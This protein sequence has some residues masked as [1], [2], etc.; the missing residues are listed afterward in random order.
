MTILADLPDRREQDLR[1][2]DLTQPQEDY[3]SY[4][5]L[6]EAYHAS[7]W[8]D[9]LPIVPP[10]PEKTVEF[11]KVVGL[12]PR[13]VVG[14]VPTRELTVSAEQLAINAVMAGC[15][16]EYMP[17]VLAAARAHLSPKGN[18]HSTTATLAGAVHLVLVNG[19]VRNELGILCREGCFG[20]GS[21]AN[22]TI[23]RALRLMIRNACHAVPGFVDRATFSHPGRYSACFGEDEEGGMRDEGAPWLPL[24]VERGFA[25]ETNVVTVY[26]LTDYYAYRDTG[27]ATPES[28]LDGLIRSA[29][30]RPISEDEHAG[31]DRAVLFVF[32]PEHRDFLIRSGWSKQRVREYLFPRLVA[33]HTHGAGIE[34]TWGMVPMAG[35]GESRFCIPREQGI[36]IVGAG[37]R[38]QSASW[39]FYPHL[40]AAVSAACTG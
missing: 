10:T 31:E 19:P 6:L 40:A 18:C 2:N 35:V 12:A 3:A 23:G 11:L 1:V 37:G 39:I 27:R 38:G 16:P 20:A 22:A 36:L 29:R 24:H 15:R 30:S 8:T 34:D 7:G 17:V 13:D 21:R 14:T 33:P 28:L 9:G 26:A 4:G 32:C 5:A 25:P